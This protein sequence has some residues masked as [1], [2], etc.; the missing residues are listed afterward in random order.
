MAFADGVKADLAR[1]LGSAGE[2]VETIRY[3]SHINGSFGPWFSAS[4]IVARVDP[5][6]LVSDGR[7][8]RAIEVHILKT[9]VSEVYV[10]RDQVEWD[11]TIWRVKDI[12][13]DDVAA[14]RLHCAA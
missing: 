7:T 2:F 4:A 10:T 9:A 12:V 8:A 3:R 5:I 14:W 6:G 11:E 13:A 1:I